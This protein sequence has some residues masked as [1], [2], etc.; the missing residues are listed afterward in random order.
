MR[1]SNIQRERV[2]SACS[3]G[4][5]DHE[6]VCACAGGGQ[7]QQAAALA[8]AQ[9]FASGGSQA[10]SFA[11]AVAQ[12]IATDGCGAIEPTLARALSLTLILY[13]IITL[14]ALPE[15]CILLVNPSCSVPVIECSSVLRHAD[16][17]FG[18]YAAQCIYIVT[19]SCAV[20]LLH[21]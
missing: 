3:P 16:L 8:L 6:K 4:R 20:A 11:A 7:S 13:I 21:A 18:M 14:H 17:K 10:S 15:S 2:L 9:A 5:L 1:S 19:C 12:A